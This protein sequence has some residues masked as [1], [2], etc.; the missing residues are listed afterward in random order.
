MSLLARV[1]RKMPAAIESVAMRADAK[2]VDFCSGYF[3]T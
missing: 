3:E 1:K 2:Q